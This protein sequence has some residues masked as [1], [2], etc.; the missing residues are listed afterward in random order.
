VLDYNVSQHI[1]HKENFHMARFSN[2]IASTPHDDR[3]DSNNETV[4]LKPAELALH[5]THFC[6]VRITKSDKPDTFGNLYWYLQVIT[7]DGEP[8]IDY[9]TKLSV[10]GGKRDDA[11]ATLRQ[12]LVAYPGDVI[13]GCELVALEPQTKGHKPYLHLTNHD[14]DACA[15]GYTA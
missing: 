12:H 13:H 4:W 15:C 7:P 1:N 3:T 9:M 5:S 2:I 14:G 10:N 11:L 6:I 8:T